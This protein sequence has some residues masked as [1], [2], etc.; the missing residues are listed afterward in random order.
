MEL[1]RTVWY[2]RGSVSLEE[3][4][5]VG[6]DDREIMSKLI[7]ENLETTKKSGQPFF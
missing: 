2:M 3:I 5:Q 4:Y 6:P 7:K 1:M